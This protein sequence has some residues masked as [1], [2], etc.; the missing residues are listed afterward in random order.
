MFYADRSFDD[1]R[2]EGRLDDTMRLTIMYFRF[3]SHSL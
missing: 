2:N 3:L 1:G